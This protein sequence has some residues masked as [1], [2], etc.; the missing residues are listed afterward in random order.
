MGTEYPIYSLYSKTITY[1]PDY[2]KKPDY[3]ITFYSK[4][5][6]LS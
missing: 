4:Y 6:K 3:P 1:K 2:S 5:L